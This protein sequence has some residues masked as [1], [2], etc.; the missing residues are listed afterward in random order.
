MPIEMP[1]KYIFLY[2][3]QTFKHV[4]NDFRYNAGLLTHLILNRKSAICPTSM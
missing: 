2:H 1:Y 4:R 3:I